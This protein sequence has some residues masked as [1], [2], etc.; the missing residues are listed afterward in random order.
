M[1]FLPGKKGSFTLLAHPI[2]LGH[3]YKTTWRICLST[4]F[5]YRYLIK[6][7]CVHIQL[8]CIISGAAGSFMTTRV[9]GKSFCRGKEAEY[10]GAC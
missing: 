10:Y 3:K 9:Q 7:L 8:V 6:W 2:V 1:F 4:T 5:M